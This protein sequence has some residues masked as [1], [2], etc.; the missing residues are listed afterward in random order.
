MEAPENGYYH[1]D[2]TFVLPFRPKNLVAAKSLTS[3]E[4]ISAASSTTTPPAQ[5]KLCSIVHH[6]NWLALYD[7]CCAADAART[8]GEADGFVDIDAT[9]TVSTAGAHAGDWL[10]ISPVFMRFNDEEYV[11]SLQWRSGS[12]SLQLRPTSTRLRL[13]AAR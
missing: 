12:S 3:V 1:F 6:S 8:P 4:A 11:F 9:R 10:N 7:A 2:G 13:R 5:R